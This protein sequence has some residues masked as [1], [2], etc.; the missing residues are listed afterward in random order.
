MVAEPTEYF[1]NEDNKD[2]DRGIT[3]EQW[4]GTARLVLI[5]GRPVS[6]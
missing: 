6:V 5:A 4:R 1:G 2:G 3:D